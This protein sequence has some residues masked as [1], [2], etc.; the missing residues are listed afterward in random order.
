[1]IKGFQEAVNRL[2]YNIEYFLHCND[3]SK[4]DLRTTSHSYST[5]S[6]RTTANRK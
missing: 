6:P 5:S 3:L 1:M 2:K 4:N